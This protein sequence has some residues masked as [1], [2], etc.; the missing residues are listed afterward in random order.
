MLKFR[1]SAIVAAFALVA[2]IASA[3]GAGTGSGEAATSLKFPA[4]SDT[5]NWRVQQGYNSGTHTGYQRYALDFVRVDG[6]TSGTQAL[7]PVVGKYVWGPDSNGCLAFDIA[8]GAR[9]MLCHIRTSRS[10]SAGQQLN[11]GDQL[12]TIAPAGQLGNNG[13]AHI[14]ISMYMPPSGVADTG[15]N[16]S[17][18]TPV[19]FDGE[20]SLDGWIFGATDVQ[21]AYAGWADMRSSNSQLSQ[22]APPPPP[23]PSTNS[24]P[25]LCEHNA[26]GGYGR[27]LEFNVGTYDLTDYS[28]NDMLTTIIIPSG[29]RWKVTVYENVIPWTNTCWGSGWIFTSGG[30]RWEINLYDGNLNFNDKAS[31]VRVEQI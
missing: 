24:V 9:L 8:G 28:F 10:F 31:C 27:C 5:G 21:N 1:K 14:H 20:Y 6:G 18:R 26:N 3:I 15:T 17:R 13:I 2:L 23:P 11:Q 19:A 16:A 12:G 25:R 4:P 29:S 22:P 7:M 30:A